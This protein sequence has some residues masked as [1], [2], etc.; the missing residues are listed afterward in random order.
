MEACN[1]HRSRE[2]RRLMHATVLAHACRPLSMNALR[3]MSVTMC[4]VKRCDTH[5]QL[6]G[7]QARHDSFK[8]GYHLNFAQPDLGT[9][10]KE[11]IC[12]D[13]LLV[14]LVSDLKCG[15]RQ[16]LAPNLGTRVSGKRLATFL[17]ES[18][19]SHLASELSAQAAGLININSDIINLLWED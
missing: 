11:A 9:E 13:D 15:P 14:F 7:I 3:K 5:T 17:E 6:N 1:L 16:E 8:R 19:D 10:K 18:L 4:Y 2:G 12:G